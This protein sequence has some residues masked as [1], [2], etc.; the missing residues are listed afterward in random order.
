V[1]KAGSLIGGNAP[2]DANGAGGGGGIYNNSGTVTLE[3]G[4]RIAGNIATQGGGIYNDSGW[5]TLQA[6]SRI[7]SNNA[8]DGGGIY[9][10]A[11]PV[12]LQTGA[13]VCSNTPA[14]KQCSGAITGTCPFPAETCDSD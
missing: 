11:G 3:T 14:H 6:D 8:D 7:D 4:S 12:T 10:F 13:L 9:S 1:L 2:E 5:V